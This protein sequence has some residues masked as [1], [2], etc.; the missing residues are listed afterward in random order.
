M[1]CIERSSPRLVQ[2]PGPSAERLPQA[3]HAEVDMDDFP[4][5][6]QEEVLPVR[7]D[8][9]DHERAGEPCAGPSPKVKA[10]RGVR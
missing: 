1:R 5:Q 6:M 2:A 8:A 4:A 9:L 3:V 10:T 7:R